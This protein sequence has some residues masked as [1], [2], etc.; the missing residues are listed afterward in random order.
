MYQ[1]IQPRET[2]I[3]LYHIAVAELADM[4]DVFFPHADGTRLSRREFLHFALCSG[5]VTE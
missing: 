3:F 2:A 5:D 4:T 1:P